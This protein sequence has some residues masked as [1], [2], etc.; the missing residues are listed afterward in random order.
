MGTVTYSDQRGRQCFFYVDNLIDVQPMPAAQGPG[1]SII[2]FVGGIERYS[3]ESPETIRSK[4]DV[5]VRLRALA[6]RP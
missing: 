5:A 3:T 4:V 2:T 6:M 1:Q